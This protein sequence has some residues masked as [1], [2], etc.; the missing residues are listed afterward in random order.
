VKAIDIHRALETLWPTKSGEWAILKE[1]RVATGYASGA[2]QFIDAWVI[3][4]WPSKNLHRIAVEIKVSRADFNH[5]LDRPLK[6]A[7][8]YRLSNEFYFAVPAGLVTPAEI[9]HD[10]GLIEVGPDGVAKITLEA[11]YHDGEP[12]SWLF[13]ASL[14]RRISKL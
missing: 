2:T 3:N 8:A 1:M 10:C 11:P 14:A 6:R 9:P 7:A 4:C 5:E 13:V 12:P